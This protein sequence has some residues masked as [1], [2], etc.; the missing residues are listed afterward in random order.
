[1]IPARH[2]L[3][4]SNISSL[5]SKRKARS[6]M[7]YSGGFTGGPRNRNL[8]TVAR[9]HAYSSMGLDILL[10]FF[11]RGPESANRVQSSAEKVPLF[12]IYKLFYYYVA[13]PAKST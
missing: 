8:V 10:T 13:P 1:M 12:Q 11:W 4:D 5:M 6:R 7:L 3:Y 9:I 2:L